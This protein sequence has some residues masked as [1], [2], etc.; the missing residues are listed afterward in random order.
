MTEVLY[1][2]TRVYLSLMNNTKSIFLKMKFSELTRFLKTIRPD[3][4]VA[5]TERNRRYNAYLKKR[6]NSVSN[7]KIVEE[8]R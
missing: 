1:E 3:K 4:Q 2:W 5:A 6:H 7:M 8:L